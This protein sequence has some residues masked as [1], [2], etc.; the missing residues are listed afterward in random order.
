MVK[1][2]K[3]KVST[4]IELSG[5]YFPAIKKQTRLTWLKYF[6]RILSFLFSFQ[7]AFILS[8]SVKRRTQHVEM[9]WE[10]NWIA[11][12]YIHAWNWINK[13]LEKSAEWVTP[14]FVYT[15][16]ECGGRRGGGVGGDMRA[17]RSGSR[18][19]EYVRGR[20]GRGVRCSGGMCEWGGLVVV[21]IYDSGCEVLSSPPPT[22]TFPPAFLIPS[23]THVVV[24]L[25]FFLLDDCVLDL[26][27]GR[28]LTHK[29]TYNQAYAYI[30]TKIIIDAYISM[31]ISIIDIHEYP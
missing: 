16:L 6:L 29:L 19:G 30:D 27:E 12:I 2:V 15:C 31:H 24:R 3:K 20:R 11:S 21:Q 17:V 13:S 4:E 28:K 25:Q 26:C 14:S 9:Q 7:H 22:T 5:T 18:K 8:S 23:S 10:P 1:R